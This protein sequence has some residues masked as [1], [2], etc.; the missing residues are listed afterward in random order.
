MSIKRR[1]RELGCFCGLILLAGCVGLSSQTSSVDQLQQRAASGDLVAERMLGVAYDF[2]Q[3][4][5]Q[6]Y[7][8][9][10]KWYQLSADQGDAIAE[11]NLGSLY[12]HGLGVPQDYSRALDLYQK[13]AKQGFAMAQNSLGRMYDQGMGVRTSYLEANKWYLLAANQGDAQAMFNLGK[14]YGFGR[15][16]TKDFVQAFMWLD[17]GRLFTQH[18]SDMKTKWTIRKA[19]DDLRVYMTPEE[20]KQG[21]RLSKDWCNDYFEK[22]KSA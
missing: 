8:E 14:N 7:T 11:N 2:G 4:A 9:A 10:A 5:Q 13:S 3:G 22:H 20:I 21:E 1:F 16:F 12:E 15:G 17:V 6:N 18:T 19:L